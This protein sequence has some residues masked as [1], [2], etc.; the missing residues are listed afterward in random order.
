MLIY[1]NYRKEKVN[2]KRNK[3]IYIRFAENTK[4]MKY[5][6]ILKLSTEFPG[7]CPLVSLLLGPQEVLRP[8]DDWGSCFCF[9]L[10]VQVGATISI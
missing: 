3:Q 10:H 7:D 6:D 5:V 2:V 9:K 8:G 4:L 1:K